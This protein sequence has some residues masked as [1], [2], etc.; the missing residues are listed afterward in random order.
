MNAKT[1]NNLLIKTEVNN[2]L[3]QFLT[4]QIDLVRTKIE[5]LIG[6]KEINKA[7]PSKVELIKTSL[8]NSEENEL[9][10]AKN[11]ILNQY[12]F[13]GMKLFSQGPF[14]QNKGKNTGQLGIYL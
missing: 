5:Q 1:M 6:A 11:E 12:Y 8:E 4:Q 9:E 13:E 10:E 7:E 2:H 3:P 14:A